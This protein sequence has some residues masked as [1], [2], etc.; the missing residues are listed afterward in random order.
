M[1]TYE[2][3][4]FISDEL[5]K[6]YIPTAEI[7]NEFFRLYLP[8]IKEDIESYKVILPEKYM[9]TYPE[10]EKMATLDW[11][12]FSK[13]CDTPIAFKNKGLQIDR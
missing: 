2:K 6:F 9:Y 11:L 7:K 13:Y 5:K 4:K 3:L 8:E 1:I 12:H 10:I